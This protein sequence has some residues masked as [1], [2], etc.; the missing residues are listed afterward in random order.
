M[1][2]VE[3]GSEVRNRRLMVGCGAV[4]LLAA[5]AHRP[6]ADIRI[7]THQ[8]SDPA[9]HCAQAV[10]DLGVVAVS[11]MYPGPTLRQYA[12][13]GN[14]YKTRLTAAHVGIPLERRAYDIMAGA[15]RSAAFLANVDAN[16]RIPVRQLG[17]DYLPESEAA[18]LY[19]ADGSPLIPH[20]RFDRADMFRRVFWEQ[21]GH[22]PN[23]A[24][25]RFWTR[26]VGEDAPRAA[27][28]AAGQARRRRGRAGLLDEH[29]VRTPFVATGRFTVADIARYAY[30]H[31]AEDGGSRS[32]IRTRPVVTLA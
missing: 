21:Y 18:C 12:A 13:S 6:S 14:R 31:V 27:R 20:D 1:C 7:L 25:L 4:L 30:T 16:G 5:A 32:A 10:V 28:A 26:F 2:F 24:T 9:P 19:P 11:L 22:E 15:T 3:R 29:L 17:D 8:A 23:I